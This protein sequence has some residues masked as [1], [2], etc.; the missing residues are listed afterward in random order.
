[1]TLDEDHVDAPV[2]PALETIARAI[3]AQDLDVD[4]T[5]SSRA[6][7][8]DPAEVA[9]ALEFAQR[10]LASVPADDA[11]LPKAAEWF[12]D[13]YY[14]I[15]R[16]ARQTEDD[17]PGGFVRHLP[18]VAKGPGQGRL[19]VELLAEALI[20]A[21]EI[22]PSPATL[23]AFVDAYQELAPLTIA[24]LWALPTMLRACVLRHLVRFLDEL[25]VPLGDDHDGRAPPLADDLRH[26]RVSPDP[27]VGVE[28]AIRALRVLDVFDWKA[29]FARS[30]RVEAILRIDPA[31]V[32]A[33]MDF[34]TCDSYRRV[35]EAL[36]WQTDRTEPAVA[37][38]A[39]ALATEHS[40]DPRGGPVGHYLV[41]GGRPSLEARVG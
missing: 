10:S 32:Y 14:L 39:V 33:G 19:R 7:A 18:R 40:S 5:A 38:L 25:H 26:P 31:G 4:R 34:A 22:E 6:H 28:C 35:V 37:E 21:T 13:N 8:R 17:L 1:V 23:R 11:T 24:E 41:G 9:T 15:R 12:L 3:A 29:F 20:G 16:V 27:G 36:A 2:A 30:S